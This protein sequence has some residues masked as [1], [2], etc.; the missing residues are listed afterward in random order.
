MIIIR[1]IR[2]GLVYRTTR[3]TVERSYNRLYRQA[4]EIKRP[5]NER[6][7]RRNTSYSR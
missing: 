6:K 2:R 4:P 3:I 1:Q 7:I 5:D